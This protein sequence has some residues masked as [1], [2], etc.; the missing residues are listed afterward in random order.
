MKEAAVAPNRTLS[1]STINKYGLY[2][3]F[4]SL[5]VM[6]PMSYQ[7]IFMTDCLGLAAGLVGGTLLIGRI[8]DLIV[9]LL[10]GGIIEKHP[11]TH[12]KYRS[13]LLLGRWIVVFGVLCQFFD[14]SALPV[15]ARCSIC[16]V[17]YMCVNC[18]M[19]FTTNAFYA[20]GPVIAG[21][22]QAGRY[23]M[24]AKGVQYST[25]AML[26]TSAATIPFIN[27][28]TPALGVGWSYFTVAAVFAIPYIF[29]CGM[30][31]R[32][33]SGVDPDGPKG[34]AS[35]RPVVTILDMVKSVV[36][37][38][39]MLA[40]F[41]VFCLY[42]VGMFMYS[43][44]LAHYYM[45]VVG[46]FNKMALNSSITTVGGVLFASI[47]PRTL[48]AKLG[49]RKAFIVGLGLYGVSMILIFV[50]FVTNWIV[51][52]AFSLLMGA[53]T[54]VFSSYSALYF[55]DVGEYYL[56]KTGKDTR[57]VAIS[58]MSVPMK[59]GMMIGSTLSLTLLGGLG[60]QPGMQVTQAFIH[61]FLRNLALIPGICVLL[62]VV[63]FILC[64]RITDKDAELYATENAKKFSMTGTVQP[65]DDD[66]Q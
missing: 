26:I 40:I 3:F 22:D 49:K 18:F 11:L 8:I 35:G 9:S 45:Y 12:G 33:A 7:N 46:D 37:N 13:W 2:M 50:C 23:K 10:A 43:G 24:N 63:V 60:Y 51:F 30:L 15:V 44:M 65:A 48:G 36:Q 20:L 16:L 31:S 57:T 6:V 32:E 17:G 14:T 28:L 53:A 21:A 25:I 29:G 19:N 27:L 41:T 62:A 34:G 52:L 59:I 55:M 4:S 61:G 58:M 39:M 47:I 56:Y 5:A 38:K 64:Y 42:Y 1:N 66:A 54:Y